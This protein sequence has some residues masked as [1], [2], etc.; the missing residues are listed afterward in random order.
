MAQENLTAFDAGVSDPDPVAW[1]YEVKRT[2]GEE[3]RKVSGWSR[4]LQREEPDP[5]S[6]KKTESEYYHLRNIVP[7]RQ[8]REVTPD[9]ALGYEF[10]YENSDS[11]VSTGLSKTDPRGPESDSLIECTPLVPINDE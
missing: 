10:E 9:N 7:L 2:V 8:S 6:W 11:G 5:D 1:S 3:G 4:H